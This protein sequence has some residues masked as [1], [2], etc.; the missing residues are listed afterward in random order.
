MK[1]HSKAC[2]HDCDACSYSSEWYIKEWLD[3]KCIVCGGDRG[4]NPYASDICW[5][6]AS[7]KDR[8]DILKEINS[9]K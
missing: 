8:M 6:R 1:L 5:L 4:K 3:G 2:P 7:D 9:R